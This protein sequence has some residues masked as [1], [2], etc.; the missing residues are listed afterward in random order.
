MYSALIFHSFNNNPH[1]DKFYDLSI[2]NFISL[3]DYLG[4]K[5]NPEKI[6]I[7]FDD[8]F[9]SIIPAVEKSLKKGYKTIVYII[10]DY[11]DKEGFLSKKDIKYLYSIG[12][13]I[14]SHSKSHKDLSKVNNDI[15]K[16]ELT[17]SKKVLEKI[18]GEE[19]IHFA[20]P[21]GS[22][23]KFSIKRAKNIYKFTAISRPNFFK[24]ENIIGRIS[25]NSHNCKRHNDILKLLT[26]N[27]SLKYILRLCLS[28]FLKTFLPNKFYISL[29]NLISK[30][31][32][33]EI[34]KIN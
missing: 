29:K 13:K 16:L 4:N 22:F 9:K 20:F 19:V 8:G 28:E 15:L 12:C 33:S 10:S 3:I 7:T 2:E 21:Y 11:I 24:E 1:S 18:I 25:I 34:F 5:I 23:N 27:I 17:E 26:K 32:S 30:N 6:I 31:K 14:G